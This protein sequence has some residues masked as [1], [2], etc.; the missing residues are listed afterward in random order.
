MPL[1][2]GSFSTLL[3]S[4]AKPFVV[5]SLGPT[6]SSSAIRQQQQQQ[7]TRASAAP[8]VT[9]SSILKSFPRPNLQ[10]TLQS[11][12]SLSQLELLKAMNPIQNCVNCSGP[13]ST[14]F[15]PC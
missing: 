6:L 10:P 7:H 11:T 4:T 8:V 1:P 5:K 12:R 14:E 15:C 2:I 9:E 3:T 13:H